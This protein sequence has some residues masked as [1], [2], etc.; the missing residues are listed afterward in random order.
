MATNFPLAKRVLATHGCNKTKREESKQKHKTNYTSNAPTTKSLHPRVVSSFLC[1]GTKRTLGIFWV[2]LDGFQV[3][4]MVRGWMSFWSRKIW[5]GMVVNGWLR[6]EME[7]G[8]LWIVNGVKDGWSV[9]N[10]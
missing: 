3:G 10:G 8:V 6:Q 5:R 4:E 7:S 9:W 2:V 1:C